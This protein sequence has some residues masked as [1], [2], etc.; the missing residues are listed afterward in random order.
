MA[1]STPHVLIDAREHDRVSRPPITVL[2]NSLAAPRLIGYAAMEA[3]QLRGQQQISVHLSRRCL[4][5]AF[6]CASDLVESSFALVIHMAV[7]QKHGQ[8][9]KLAESGKRFAVLG[10]VIGV[11]PLT[12]FGRG[13]PHMRLDAEV[14]GDSSD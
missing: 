1:R 9:V 2:A 5:S 3:E 6:R 14:F 7:H 11:R 12:E 4:T 10:N 13:L 8:L